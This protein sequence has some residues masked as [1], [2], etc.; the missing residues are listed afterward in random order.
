MVSGA[1]MRKGVAG[2][3]RESAE[4]LLAYLLSDTVQGLLAQETFEY[5][6]VQGVQNHPD[7]EPLASI[8]LAKVDKAH[9]TDVG[10][11]LNTLRDLDL[12]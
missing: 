5:P 12:Q 11:T 6:V 4:K 8:A 7:V 2:K 1:A 10:P 3:H 9:L